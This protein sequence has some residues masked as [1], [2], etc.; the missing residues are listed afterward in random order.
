MK[1][2]NRSKFISGKEIERFIVK[3]EAEL[4][5]TVHEMDLS[6]TI[7]VRKMEIIDAHSSMLRVPYAHCHEVADLAKKL[8][9]LKVIS[10]G[11]AKNVSKLMGGRCGCLVLEELA[12]DAVRAVSQTSATIIPPEQHE[13]IIHKFSDGTCYT[14]CMPIKEKT[15]AAYPRSYHKDIYEKLKTRF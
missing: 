5:D 2:F 8:I 1:L 7:D 10:G 13:Q 14:H 12:Q 3:I 11:Q 6:I 4:I 9:G 15:E